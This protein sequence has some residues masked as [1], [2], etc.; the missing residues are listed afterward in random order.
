[1]GLEGSVRLEQLPWAAAGFAA[2]LEA[3]GTR[4]GAGAEIHGDDPPAPQIP[5]AG[6]HLLASA[7]LGVLCPVLGSSG[8]QGPLGEAVEMRRG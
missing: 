7:V 4:A 1:M 3:A 2:R 5:A 6:S 8:Q